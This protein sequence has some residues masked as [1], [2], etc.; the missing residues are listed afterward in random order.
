ME[1]FESEKW[2]KFRNFRANLV[3]FPVFKCHLLLGHSVPIKSSTFETYF[4][5]YKLYC[6]HVIDFRITYCLQIIS[7][8]RPISEVSDK[9]R[10]LT[11]PLSI[12]LLAYGLEKDPSNAPP[13]SGLSRSNS[14]HLYEHHKI[15]L[16]TMDTYPASRVQIHRASPSE[17]QKSLGYVGSAVLRKPQDF[18]TSLSSL[19]IED[20][21]S[22]ST[23]QFS[24]NTHTDYRGTSKQ[25]S[26]SGSTYRLC[27]L[28]VIIYNI[29]SV[30]GDKYICLIANK[31]ILLS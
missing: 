3:E 5:H 9:S 14:A 18:S 4:I 27:K 20:I 28:S 16:G 22:S 21:P 26:L 13:H 29:I 1:I 24:D 23:D 6:I 17:Q 12:R 2:P 7:K 15:K 19:S 8:S 10:E 11:S 31:Q 25:R 30:V